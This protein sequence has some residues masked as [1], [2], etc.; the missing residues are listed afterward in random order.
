MDFIVTNKRQQTMIERIGEAASLIDDMRFLP[1]YRSIQIKLE[2][3]GHADEWE[4]MIA[5][6]KTKENANRYFAKLCKMVKLG[7]YQF[8]K[9]VKE[10]ASHMKS[11]ITEKIQRFGFGESYHDYWM[12]KVNEYINVNGMNG[13]V[14]LMEMADRRNMSQ[15]YFAKAIINC[16]APAT[17]YKE[18]VIGGAK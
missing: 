17:Y 9:A 12:R 4:K 11:F 15:K 3:M 13:F 18:N 8:A 5:V 14:A 10:V 1:F 7:T 2:K 16:K 6:A